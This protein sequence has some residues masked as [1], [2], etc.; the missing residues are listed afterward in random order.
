M[1]LSPLQLK[2]SWIVSLQM[3]TPPRE[4]EVSREVRVDVVPTY[5]RSSERSNEW[6]VTLDT[7]VS[8]PDAGISKYQLSITVEGYFV[9]DESLE[10][11]KAL[12]IVAVNAPS[13]LYSATREIV[14]GLTARAPRGRLNLP[15][16]SF[17]GYSIGG[18]ESVSERVRR[19]VPK[20]K[21]TR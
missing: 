2:E 9:V 14:V 4:A 7:E 5:A 11:E 21:N 1:N 10:E 20:A 18:K 19:K 13:V 8:N 16:L 12:R 17:G 15:T 3:E 6:R